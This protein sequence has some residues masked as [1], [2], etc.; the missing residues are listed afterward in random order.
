ME[1]E[2]PRLNDTLQRMFLRVR[3][4]VNITRP[5]PTGFWLATQNHQT[6]WVDFKYERI[7]DSYCLNYGVLGHTKKEC[8]SP[9]AVASWDHM[10]PKYGLG[11][12]QGMD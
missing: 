3:V 8:S 1:T 11:N 9:M 7:Q 4:T 12:E 2:N 5:L 6:L 10:Q